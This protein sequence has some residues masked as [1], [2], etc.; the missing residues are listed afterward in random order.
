MSTAVSHGVRWRLEV[1]LDS[2]RPL[3]DKANMEVATRIRRWRAHLGLTLRQASESSGLTVWQ[4]S[5]AELGHVSPPAD[6]LTQL[7][8]QGFRLRMARFW[9]RMPRERKGRRLA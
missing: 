2:G 3:R 7:V 6:R 9:G 1:W 5:N 4:I 8:T